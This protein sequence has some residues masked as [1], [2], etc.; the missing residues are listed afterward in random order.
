MRNVIEDILWHFRFL[1]VGVVARRYWNELVR[2]TFG[3][4]RRSQLMHLDIRIAR[5]ICLVA[6]HV[7]GV[8]WE[9]Q[10]IS[11]E[12]VTVSF[13]LLHPMRTT[14]FRGSQSNQS[15]PNYGGIAR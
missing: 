5:V 11:V 8:Y 6:E 3:R 12:I 15:A 2:E 14:Q 1:L 7:G 9:D 10:D 4:N 13:Y